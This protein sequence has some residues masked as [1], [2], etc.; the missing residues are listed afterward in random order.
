MRLVLS[1]RV[2]KQFNTEHYINENVY[3]SP[4]WAPPTYHF[5]YEEHFRTVIMNYNSLNSIVCSRKLKNE[6][7]VQKRNQQL[8]AKYGR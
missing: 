6:L 5:G 7:N 8:T 2:I 1:V 4:R 3:M